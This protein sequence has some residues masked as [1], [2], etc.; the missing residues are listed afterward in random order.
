MTTE[1][2]GPDPSAPGLPAEPPGLLLAS[3]QDV[4]GAVPYLLGFHPGDSLIVIGLR[5][6]PPRG[7][8][9]LTVR[10]DLPLAAPAPGRILP[11]LRKEEIT[12][13]IAVGY[14]PGPLVTPAA[15][16]VIALLRGSG[17]AVLDVLRAHDGRYWSYLCQ[18]AECCPPSGTP[19]DREAGPIAAQATVHGLVALPDRRTLERSLAPAGGRERTAMRRATARATAE[20]RARLAGCRDVDGLAAELVADGVAR[21]HGAIAAY[22]SGGRI[23]DEQA[24]RLGLGLAVI[25]IRDE[26]WALITDDTCDAHVRLWRD[27]TRRLEP[28]FAAPAASLLGMAAW[29]GGDCAL[30]GIALARALDADPGYSMAHLLM[31]ALRHLLPPHA[32][33]ER[34]PSPE[35]LDQEMGGARAAW[36]LPVIALLEERRRGPVAVAG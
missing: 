3:T 35:E 28:R 6:D 1:T 27:L 11:L 31:Q 18:A 17:I 33:K 30:A 24:A 23:D 25:R 14:G 9:H 15:D 21:V 19:Y 32:L 12:Q 22:A 16:A 13:V 34:M 7:R 4:L 10:W 29:R 2:P 8:V 20:L 5:G 26:A 36:L